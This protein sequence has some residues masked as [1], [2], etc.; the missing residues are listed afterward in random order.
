MNTEKA[1][2]SAQT[3]QREDF[4]KVADILKQGGVGVF[5]TDTTYAIGAS[6]QFPK[7]LDRAFAMKERPKDHS[8]PLLI[9]RPEVALEIAM[10][11]EKDLDLL[12]R[13]WPGPYTLILRTRLRLPTGLVGPDGTVALRCPDHG[14]ALDLLRAVGDTLAVTSANFSGSESPV[15][16]RDVDPAILEHADAA[17]DA[18]PCPLPG[19]TTIWKVAGREPR[20]VREGCVS[21]AEIDRV[22]GLLAGLGR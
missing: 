8:L 11:Q 17:L 16:F 15:D 10:L 22:G 4:R 21:P 5:P 7:A 18:G 19:G 3:Y 1:D 9:S 6:I 13:I 12:K 20:L 2:M 14:V